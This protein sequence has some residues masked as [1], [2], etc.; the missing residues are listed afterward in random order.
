MAGKIQDNPV[1]LS[2]KRNLEGTSSYRNSFDVLTNNDLMLR[3]SNMGVIIP[4]S[5]FSSVD[6]LRELEKVRENN[7]DVHNPSSDNQDG[8]CVMYIT[9][10]K[11]D[12]TPISTEWG[13]EGDDPE[14]NFILV[15]SRRKKSPKVKIAIS[16]P[17]TR[18]QKP[19]IGKDKSK[20]GRHVHHYR[21]T[22]GGRK[23][24]LN[25]RNILE[26]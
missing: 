3:E 25:D 11:G 2:K 10:G 24:I 9:N 12:Q 20:A 14:A 22:R 7:N 26:L 5:N 18:S 15:K 6:I 23:V 4:D 17:V 19:D 1:V 13:D 21:A 8:G 16:R